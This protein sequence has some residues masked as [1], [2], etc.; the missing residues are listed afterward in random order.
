MEELNFNCPAYLAQRFWLHC[1]ERRETPGAVLRD[2]MMTEIA[3]T[4]ASFEFDLKEM[5]GFDA[6][7]VRQGIQS[8]K[9]KL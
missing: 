3:K 2:F 9:T 4:D 8:H 7:S 1:S 6:W 5:T